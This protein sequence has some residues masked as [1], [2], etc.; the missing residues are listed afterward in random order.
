MNIASFA[1]HGNMEYIQQQFENKKLETLKEAARLEVRNEIENRLA[2][3]VGTALI[4]GIVIGLILIM[5]FVEGS[6]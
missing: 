6:L 1:N 3:V 2:K 4:F 5:G